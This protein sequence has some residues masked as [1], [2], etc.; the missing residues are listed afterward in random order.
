MRLYHIPHHTLGVEPRTCHILL[1]LTILNKQYAYFC[2][3]FQKAHTNP[4]NKLLKRWILR[5]LKEA[6]LVVGVKESVAEAQSAK[7]LC[8]AF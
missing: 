2:S 5:R 3:T 7:L 8:L 1:L 4:P 6:I